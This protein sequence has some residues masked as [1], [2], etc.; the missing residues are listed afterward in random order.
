MADTL[1][2]VKLKRN[3]TLVVVFLLLG[4]LI[5]YTALRQDP[6]EQKILEMKSRMLAK[7]LSLPVQPGLLRR[8]R[9]TRA[10]SGLDARHRRKNLE[11]AFALFSIHGRMEYDHV[12]LVDD[13]CT[14]GETLAACTRVLQQ[15]GVSTISVWVAARAPPP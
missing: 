11:G 4:G 1:A 8:V 12:A 7:K 9:R 13:V 6:E 10:Q 14:T 2:K 5:A 3:I 15:A